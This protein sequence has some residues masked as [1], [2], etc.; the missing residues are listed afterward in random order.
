MINAGFCQRLVSATIELPLIQCYVTL[1]AF[2]AMKP[3]P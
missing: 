1:I 3:E 2:D